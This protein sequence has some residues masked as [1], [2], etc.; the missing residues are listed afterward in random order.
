[1][2]PRSS[3]VTRETVTSFSPRGARTQATLIV[4][5][6]ALFAGVMIG[7]GVGAVVEWAAETDEGL[8]AIAAL[9]AGALAFLAVVVPLLPRALRIGISWTDSEIE[10]VNLSGTKRVAWERVVGLDG[11]FAHVFPRGFPVLAIRTNPR[12][13]WEHVPIHA[14]MG[15]KR[16]EETDVG[17]ALIAEMRRRGL[18]KEDPLDASRRS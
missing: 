2:E 15:L 1:M 3:G 14:T 4:V 13:I 18:E 8:Q 17:L 6:R 12:N 7:G 16:P 9:G 11:A 5:S 10:V